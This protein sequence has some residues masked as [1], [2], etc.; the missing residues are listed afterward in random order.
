MKMEAARS[1]ETLV[2]SCETAQLY[3]PEDFKH[4]RKEMCFYTDDR[5]S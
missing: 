1:F 5:T 2:P 3:N 4:R